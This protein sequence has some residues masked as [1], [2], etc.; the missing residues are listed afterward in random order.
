MS[1]AENRG[2]SPIISSYYFRY[3]FRHNFSTNTNKA[4]QYGCQFIHLEGAF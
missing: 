3:Y 2:L 4:L 1:I